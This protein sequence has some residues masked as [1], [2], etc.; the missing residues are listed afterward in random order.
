LLLLPQQDEQM[1]VANQVTKLGVGML[2]YPEKMNVE[3]LQ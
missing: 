2:L 1:V 3:Y